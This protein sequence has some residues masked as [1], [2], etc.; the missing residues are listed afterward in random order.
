MK[1]LSADWSK[2]RIVNK[3]YNAKEIINY[4]DEQNARRLQE[5]IEDAIERGDFK[6]VPQLAINYKK[7]SII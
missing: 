7:I 3:D 4:L 6:K 1:S 2:Y 5:D